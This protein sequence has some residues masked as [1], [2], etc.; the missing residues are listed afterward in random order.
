M[1]AS[2][3]WSRATPHNLCPICGK[4]DCMIGADG[5]IVHCRRVAGGSFKTT[6][7]GYL[8]RLKDDHRSTDYRGY[9]IHTIP[10]NPNIDFSARMESYRAALHPSRLTEL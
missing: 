1:T 9:R 4:W 5:A 8:H 7:A 6:N 2:I 10:T 3:D